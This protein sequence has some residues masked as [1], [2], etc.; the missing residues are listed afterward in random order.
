MTTNSEQQTP[1]DQ[2]SLPEHNYVQ[3]SKKCRYIK[4][5]PHETNIK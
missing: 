5:M 1:G 2:N 3:V 4:P